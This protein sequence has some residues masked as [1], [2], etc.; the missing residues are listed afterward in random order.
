VSYEL[1]LYNIY[2]F[3]EFRDTKLK[4]IIYVFFGATAQIGRR[5]T[6]FEVFKSHKARHT[7]THTYTRQNTF[8]QTINMSQKPLPTKNTRNT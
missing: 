4:E 6:R 3:N 5:Q 8:K 1:S 2:D 7:H